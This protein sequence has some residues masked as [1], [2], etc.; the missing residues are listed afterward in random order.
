MAF[1]KDYMGKVS[2][3]ANN[4]ALKVW[5]YNGTSSG[6]NETLATIAGSGYFNSF[7]QSLVSGS[8]NGP[9]AVGDTIHLNGND[10]NA[11]Y[12]VTSITSNVT[13]AAYSA[14]GT[15]DTADLAADAVT[16]AKI[17]PTVL[18]Y[19]AVTMSSAEFKGAYA[20]PHLLVAA[21]G[22]DT[23]VVLEDC[24]VLMTYGT[25]QYA[26]GGVSHIQWDSTANGAGVIASSTQ[27]AA[28]WFDA[29]STANAYSPGAV[30]APFANVVNKGL[31]F[32]NIT[33]A[34]D[35][36]DSN[37]VVHIWYRIVPSV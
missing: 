1:S 7:Q 18:K 32:S 37:F 17:D 11:L 31:Y 12:A 5:S 4:D 22:A 24:M 33:G 34:F 2:S 28:D 29:A 19:A 27:A 10:N 23:L 13:V 20:A 36:G 26:N 30:K 8:E 15:V 14:T 6:S 25:T 3:S 16:S 9:L 35:T 21:G